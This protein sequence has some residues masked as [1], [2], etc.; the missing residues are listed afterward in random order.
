MKLART[1][2]GLL[3][4]AVAVAASQALAQPAAVHGGTVRVSGGSYTN[5]GPSTLRQML[6]KK[7]FF[8]LNVH[9]PYEGEI[10]GT[11]AN[12]PFDR[13]E[14]SI[15]QLPSDRNAPLVVYCR[16]GRMSTTAVETLVRLGFTS[17]W[18]LEGGFIA[19]KQAGYPL[20]KR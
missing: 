12:V 6:L 18:H 16:S 9:V 11:D 13:I 10:E 19:W 17:V 7:N 15:G 14:Q 4:V 8:L 20:I 3:L 2:I 5:V 1:A